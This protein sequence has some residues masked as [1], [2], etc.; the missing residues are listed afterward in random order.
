MNKIHFRLVYNRKKEVKQVWKSPYSGGSISKSQK[1][2]H[3]VRNLRKSAT[4]GQFTK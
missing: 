4:M 3:F 1:D 2:L